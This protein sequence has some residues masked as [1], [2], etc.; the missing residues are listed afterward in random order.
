MS[1]AQPTALP[2]AAPARA[3]ESDDATGT[4]GSAVAGLPDGEISQAAPPR[5]ARNTN[6][7]CRNC[8]STPQCSCTLLAARALTLDSCPPHGEG[9]EPESTLRKRKEKRLNATGMRVNATRMRVNATECKCER[10]KYTV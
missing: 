7:P 3:H 8:I 10:V 9:R 5:V 2:P 1:R 4:V 6:M